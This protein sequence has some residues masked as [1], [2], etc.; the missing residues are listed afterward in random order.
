MA[1]WR[2]GAGLWLCLP[3]LGAQAVERHSSLDLS[4]SQNY[5]DSRGATQVTAWVGE[6]SPRLSLGLTGA[7]S[8]LALDYGL[9][10]QLRTP[11]PSDALYHRFRL[12]G[13]RSLLQRRL[14]VRAG[15]DRSQTILT[16]QQGLVSDYLI[17]TGVLS[18][19]EGYRLGAA[20]RS[21]LTP[22]A[23]LGAEVD[24]R[25][26]RYLDGGGT[27]DRQNWRVGLSQGSW[28]RRLAWTLSASGARSEG[29]G[30]TIEQRQW[31]A[32]LGVLLSRRWSAF[33][34]V[35]AYRYD[36]PTVNVAAGAGGGRV[37]LAG[38]RH[39]P[40]R[41][42]Q[43]Q[44]S[45]QRGFFG[46]G[47]TGSLD[48]RHRRVAVQLVE[49]RQLIN[50]LATVG[51]GGLAGGGVGAAP[52]LPGGGGLPGAGGGLPGVS[53]LGVQNALFVSRSRRLS[54]T[55][56]GRRL[57][58]NLYYARSVFE[59]VDDGR[60]TRYDDW[61]LAPGLRLGGRT[62]LGASLGGRRYSGTGVALTRLTRASLSLRYR[63]GA[64]TRLAFNG[65]YYRQRGGVARED[66]RL[67]LNL[68]YRWRP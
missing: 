68:D 53:P 42:A 56:R 43:L 26:S 34:Q 16:P 49:S 63:L 46:R 50:A 1:R 57:Q 19:V 36:R 2:A 6:V 47:L 18:D 39:R 48:Y 59:G 7:R 41:R 4:V 44:L 61:G 15:V 30:G 55:Y 65:S 27:S 23:R 52:G 8:R 17:G 60:S 24:W 54:L 25:R 14:Q 28:F 37:Y 9:R 64:R 12:D 67:S 40:H 3:V 22:L 45:V 35:Q 5:V 29:R 58:Q 10:A 66:L 11:G 32:D 13:E 38:M 21:R 33:A 51:T 62:E 31:L 20:W